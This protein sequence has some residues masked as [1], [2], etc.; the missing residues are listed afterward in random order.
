MLYKIFGRLIDLKT[1]IGSSKCATMHDALLPP[2]LVSMANLRQQDSPT[3][4]SR[5]LVGAS[6]QKIIGLPEK[7]NQINKEIKRAKIMKGENV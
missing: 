2:P 4:V 3:L 5:L 7:N 6:A 1:S